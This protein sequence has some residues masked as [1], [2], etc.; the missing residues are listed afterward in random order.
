MQTLNIVFPFLLF[1]LI[2]VDPYMEQLN[3]RVFLISLG[4]YILLSLLYVSSYTSRISNYYSRY[5]RIVF[6][7]YVASDLVL[8][9]PTGW[10]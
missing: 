10:R 2:H 1:L 3:Y 6:L 7:Q 8:M 9:F 5:H 4:S